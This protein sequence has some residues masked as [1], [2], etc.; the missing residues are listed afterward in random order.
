M[1][2]MKRMVT[3]VV[4]AV[5]SMSLCGVSH[6]WFTNGHRVAT[7]QAFRLLPKEMPA[8]FIEGA[9]TAVGACGDPDLFALRTMPELRNAERPDHY[10][11]IEMLRGEALPATRYEFVALC[12]RK[13]LDPSRVGLLPYAVTEWT[14]R[15]TIAFAE[16]RRWPDNKHVQ[17]KCL[18]YAGMLAHYSE[19]LW[20]PLHTTVH[21]DGRAK[22]DGSSPQSGIHSRVDAL[23]EKAT[24]DTAAL[25]V[26]AK[27]SAL[28]PLLGAVMKE[29]ERSH[30][31]V[32]AVYALEGEM[33]AAEAP[34]QANTKTADFA[35]ERMAAAAGFTGSLFLTAWKNSEKFELPAWHVNEGK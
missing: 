16:H 30:A 4:G 35:A 10:L 21:F 33:P 5:F 9:E 29:F 26:S 19:D 15:L 6:A 23:I 12:A 3:L 28:T 13:K 2:H 17:A 14:E 1:P 22:E 31:L 25:T 32:D 8:F 34:I 20:Q 11:D 18:I 27:V 24:T 7:R